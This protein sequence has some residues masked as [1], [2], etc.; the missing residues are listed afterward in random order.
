[1]SIGQHFHI[2]CAER[3]L[4]I[5]ANTTILGNV[6]VTNI[7]HEYKKLGIHILRQPHLISDTR[8]GENCFI[9]YGAAIQAGTVLG[10]QCVVGANS[11]VRGVFPDYCVIVGAP[12]RIVKRYDPVRK[13]WYRTDPRGEF[14]L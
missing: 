5:G 11:V 14:V 8:I 3:E 4:I 10:R 2:T 1:M 13:G 6:F 12:A 9:G 7:D